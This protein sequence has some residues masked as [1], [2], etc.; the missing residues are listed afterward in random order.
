MS[1]TDPNAI[2]AAVAIP[3]DGST[4]PKETFEAKVLSLIEL[5]HKSPLETATL[6]KVKGFAKRELPSFLQEDAVSLCYRIASSVPPQSESFELPA[7]E[8]EE[9]A[10]VSEAVN[11]FLLSEEV[12]IYLK[13]FIQ[14]S[15][16]TLSVLAYFALMTW[17]CQGLQCVPYLYITSSAPAS[18]KSTLARAVSHLCHRVCMVS[19]ASSPAAL[20][21]LCNRRSC[22]IM[23]DEMDSAGADFEKITPILNAGS[24]VDVH[25]VI[26]D[27]NPQGRQR[28][29]V[30]SSFGP[31]ILVGLS[32]PTGIKSLQAATV[33]RC[34]VVTSQALSFGNRPQP[35]PSFKL[36]SRAAEL[37]RKLAAMA[38]QYS[39][40]FQ[41]TLK[42]VHALDA[43]PSR[44]RD[45]YL[46]LMALATI[47]DRDRP[48]GAITDV[49]L[50]RTHLRT[51][52][53]PES[54][55]GRFL[56]TACRRVIVELLEPALAESKSSTPASSLQGMKLEI[57]RSSSYV[58][59][60][61][62]HEPIVVTSPAGKVTIRQLRVLQSAGRLFVKS[63]E[64]LA[65]LL[66]DATSPLQTAMAGKPMRTTALCRTL[67]AYGCDLSRTAYDRSL[68]SLDILKST[69]AQW[70]DAA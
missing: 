6:E 21:R 65:V 26:V 37:R 50:I 29:G 49:D 31:K 23:I 39:K 18:G 38:V 24:S 44:T 55:I 64:L 19:S 59:C 1:P 54:D 12:K 41:A 36:D 35:L 68:Y 67:K 16:E 8:I 14:V 70:V 20:S 7:L 28:L 3:K 32:G 57:S 11:V 47:A 2:E 10:P 25:R 17:L 13:T 51:A 62:M 30:L 43:L 52:A 53:V 9:T 48:P 61:L 66:C 15:P 58:V 63:T 33:S 46:P 34:I 40:D 69:I 4:D 42:E 60:A 22:T 45:R 56:L 27:R 5:V